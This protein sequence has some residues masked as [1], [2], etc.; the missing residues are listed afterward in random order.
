[1]SLGFAPAALAASAI[2]CR[3]RD[4]NCSGGS[5]TLPEAGLSNSRPSGQ[6][7]AARP[8]PEVAGAK[9]KAKDEV[10]VG[11]GWHG[12]CRF[13]GITMHRAASRQDRCM[14]TAKMRLTMPPEPY[15]FV[16]SISSVLASIFSPAW[17]LKRALKVSYQSLAA[18]S[19]VTR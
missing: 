19:A 12:H 4:Q 14:V 2:P 13:S 9:V 3:S 17:G 18:A 8:N 6:A 10:H 16:S 1:M 5:S 7:R 11:S 15:Y